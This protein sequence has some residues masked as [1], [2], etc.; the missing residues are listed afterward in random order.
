MTWSF[1]DLLGVGEL[2]DAAEV[3][4]G[5]PRADL[6]HHGQVVRDEDV[7]QVELG[8]EGAKE[9]EDLGLDGDVERR[10]R[11][12]AD[13]QLRVERERPRDSDPLALSARE[14]VRVAACVLA[15]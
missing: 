13:D 11:L 14:L 9:V 5:D 4:H 3:H 15:D 12:V 7:G 1:E 8:L 2:D 6:P 10:Y